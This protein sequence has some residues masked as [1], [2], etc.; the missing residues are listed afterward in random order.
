MAEKT[1]KPHKSWQITVNNYTDANVEAFRAWS[2]DVTRLVVAHEVGET[3]T[4]HL[5]VFVTFRNARRFTAMRKLVPGYHVEP[6][7]LNDALYQKK[8]NDTDYII[9]EIDNRAQGRRSDLADAIEAIRGGATV[10]ALWTDHTACMVRNHRGLLEAR[11]Q[12]H[13]RVCQ[14]AY[15][16]W[17]WPRIEDFSKSIILVGAAG[18]GKT[19]YAKQHFTNALFVTHI[20]NLLEFTPGVHDGIIF[21]DMAFAKLPRTAQIHL[22]DI[23]NDNSIHCRFRAAL[24][25]ARTPHIFTTN[26]VDELFDLSDSAIARR[27]TVVTVTEVG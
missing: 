24:I 17:R 18:I 13:P 7:I 9:F 19:E 15:T 11:A 26:N 14:S 12:L 5:Q 25:P 1:N 16:D 27:V 6:S 8:H 20:D 10:Q 22:V 4:P 21:D 23:D 3:G 2:N